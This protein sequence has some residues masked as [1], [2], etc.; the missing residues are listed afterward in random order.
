[1]K[2]SLAALA[3]V[4]PFGLVAYALGYWFYQYV[5]DPE[6]AP[7]ITDVPGLVVSYARRGWLVM[8]GKFQ[9]GASANPVDIATG[10]IAQQESF[11]PKA[12]P[13]PAGQTKLYSIGYGHQIVDRDGFDR[14]STISESDAAALLASDLQRY[15]ACVNNAL[16]VD[17]SAPQ[18]AAL[19]SFCYNEGCGAFVSSTLLK[20]INA[21]NLADVPAQLAR[22]NIAGGV[23]SAALVQRR[24]DEANLFA[25]GTQSDTT[26]V[27]A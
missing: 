20:D 25:S 3:V 2:K 13:D 16:T 7:S 4:L 9:F 15:V 26:G 6:N 14:T 23:V 21:G 22:W 27:T 8:K 12:Y 5:T 24:Q 10:F 19:Y 17:L 11:S 18:L 1:M